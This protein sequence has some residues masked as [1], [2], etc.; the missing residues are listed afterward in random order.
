MLALW[1][2]RQFL[3]LGRSKLLDGFAARFGHCICRNF[4]MFGVWLAVLAYLGSSIPL[5]GLVL[6][7]VEPPKA[8]GTLTKTPA[9]PATCAMTVR[10]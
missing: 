10:A 4:H 9:T 7:T 6:R 1:E 5:S 2:L 3:V 8:A